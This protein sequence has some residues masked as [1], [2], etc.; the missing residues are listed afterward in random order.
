VEGYEFPIIAWFLYINYLAL[1]GGGGGV[2]GAVVNN[3]CVVDFLVVT[4]LSPYLY[5]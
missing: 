3:F 2:G 5:I 1:G 4:H